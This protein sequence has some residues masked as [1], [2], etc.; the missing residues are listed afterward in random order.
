[1]FIG[2]FYNFIGDQSFWVF[3]NWS[4]I[5]FL[6]L[7][8]L[9][10]LSYMCISHISFQSVACIF[11]FLTVY[12]DEGKFLTFLMFNLSFFPFILSVSCLKFFAYS[13]VKKK[14]V[15]C[16]FLEAWFSNFYVY[17]YNWINFYVGYE[18][19]V[20]INFLHCGYKI[21]QA[22]FG[23]QTFIERHTFIFKLTQV[24]NILWIVLNFVKEIKFIIK[25]FPRKKH[26]IQIT[27]LVKT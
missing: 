3:L 23:E 16:F 10:P 18:V 4:F 13:K 25:S 19:G 27:I 20:N 12:F 7:L 21:V 8:G 17:E 15:F 24:G 14:N 9:S 6:Y 2:H 11:I 5:R 22:P 1:M 26:H